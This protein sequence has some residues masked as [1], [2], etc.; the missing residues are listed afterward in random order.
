MLDEDDDAES[1]DSGGVYAELLSSTVQHG[2]QIQYNT[3]QLS[4]TN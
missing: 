1:E 4:S 2:Q 3:I